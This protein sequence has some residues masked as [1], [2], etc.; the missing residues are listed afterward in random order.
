MKE[1]KLWIYAGIF[2]AVLL[3]SFLLYDEAED[4]GWFLSEKEKREKGEFMAKGYPPGGVGFDTEDGNY[5]ESIDKTITPEIILKDY[6][7]WAEYPPNSRPL[8]KYNPDLL[9]PDFIGMVAIPMVDRPEDKTPNGYS[10]KL[11]PL[12]WAAIGTR[13]PIYIT[14]ECFDTK[15]QRANLDVRSVKFWREFDGQKFGSVLPDYNDKGIDGDV[16]SSDNLYTF[17]WRP[18]PKD[19]GDMYL[20]AEFVYGKEKKE[21]KLLTSFFSS[22]NQP[23]EWSGYFSDSPS[24]GSLVIKAGLNIFKAGNYHLEANLVHPGS[25]SPI[26]WAS[27]DGKLQGGRQEVEFLFFGKLLKDAGFDGPYSIQQL[28]GHR[29]NLPIDPEWFKQGEAGMKKI[30]AAKSTEPDKELIAPF[31]DSYATRT[32]DLNTFSSKAWQSPEKEQKIQSLR[33]LP[34]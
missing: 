34:Q 19:W 11:Q 16:K 20:E 12:H 7:E 6:M 25:G 13:D 28:R 3:I 30:L 10:C 31:K 2:L 17:S 15:M 33:E 22:P 23:A 24:D 21:G 27:F 9:Q 1:R 18:S 29:V 4:Q 5:L 32:Y 14:L 26:A 8:T